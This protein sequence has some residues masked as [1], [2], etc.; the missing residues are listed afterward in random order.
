MLQRRRCAERTVQSVTKPTAKLVTWNGWWER[1]PDL[2]ASEQEAFERHG[3]EP[4]V[5]HQKNGILIIELQWPVAP[6]ETLPLSV[7]YS[8]F[9]PFV[10]PVVS[11][12]QSDF[13]RHQHPLA[14]HLCLIPDEPGMWNPQQQVADYLSERIPRLLGALTAREAE[15]WDEAA[16]LEE[17]TPDPLLPYYSGL[18]EPG[19]FVLFDSARPMP[20]GDYGVATFRLFQR[21]HARNADA[22]EAILTR[23]DPLSGRSLLPDFEPFAYARSG[24]RIRGRWIRMR[25][26][27]TEDPKELLAAVNETVRAKT[28]LAIKDARQLSQLLHPKLSLTVIVFEDEATYSPIREGI[29]CLILAERR[30]KVALVRSEPFSNEFMIRL[31]IA[32]RLRDKSVVLAGVGAVGSFIAV[33]LARAGI[34]TIT[35]IDNDIVSPGNSVRWPVGREAW[36]QS[37]I[38]GLGRFIEGNY[39]LTVVRG[40]DVKIGGTTA[41]VDEAA[42]SEQNTLNELRRI[43]AE[44]DLIVEATGSTE[45]QQAIAYEAR[46]LGKPFISAYGTPGIAGGIVATFPNSS[47]SCLICMNEH[48]ADGSLPGPVENKDAMVTPR[49]CSAPTFTGGSYDLQEVSLE[50]VREAITLLT[51]EAPTADATLDIVQ[52]SDE[53]GT[54]NLPKWDRHLIS[55]HCRCCGSAK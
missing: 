15:K 17:H 12:P 47:S 52:L 51:D 41:A 26:P 45:A 8:I 19:S 9:H 40:F 1:W 25:P 4:K 31:P 33:E 50:A 27:P 28:A 55:P 49:G 39:P 34:G 46:E 35:I 14:K 5:V 22:F 23:L 30:K 42:K 29:S 2:W 18:G 21:P 16:E 38:H 44:T 3:V 32:S 11:A 24:T 37:K 48:W 7:G 6:D 54:R 13:P 43:F 20:Q 53:K 36:G 10:R